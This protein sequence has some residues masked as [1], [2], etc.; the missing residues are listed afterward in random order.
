MTITTPESGS[1]GQRL[2]LAISGFL[3]A[4][5]ILI[6]LGFVGSLPSA[7]S[8]RELATYSSHQGSYNGLVVSAMAIAWFTVPFL[9]GL[10]LVLGAEA[11]P[12]AAAGALSIATGIVM[13]SL[14]IVLSIGILS[15]LSQLPGGSEYTAP[16]ALEGAAWANLQGTVLSF[17]DVFLGIGLL[18]LGWLTLGGRRFPRWLGV[19][20]LVGGVGAVASLAAD[21]AAIL[22]FAALVI[23]G[24][25]GGV[26]V[27]TRG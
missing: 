26:L 6:H 23:W 3:S 13:T 21:A 9:G 4:A 12:L 15:A 24:V 16:A 14:A 5:A 18:I 20:A 17:A 27:M 8:Y 25:A 2:A 11:R 19:V 7:A 10:C 22:P 1:R